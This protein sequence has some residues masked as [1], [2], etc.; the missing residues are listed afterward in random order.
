MSHRSVS[1]VLLRGAPMLVA[2]SLLVGPAGR[3]A[4]REIHFRVPPPVRQ[5]I[6]SM[7]LIA[8]PADAAE[9]RINSSLHRLD[10]TVR[11]AAETCRGFDGRPGGW[12]RSVD[13]TM[14]GPGYV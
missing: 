3:A 4:D 8:D 10:A 6:A 14:R 11:K 9:S 12:R 7:P 13:V 2:R 1:G 5:N